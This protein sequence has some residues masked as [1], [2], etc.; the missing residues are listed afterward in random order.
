MTK[1]IN[2][3]YETKKWSIYDDGYNI[4]RFLSN[5]YL[6]KYPI[7]IPF[8]TKVI[9]FG[10]INLFLK[11]KYLM[12]FFRSLGIKIICSWFHLDMSERNYSNFEKFFNYVDKWHV[13]NNEM[14]ENLI[15][16]NI[17]KNKIFIINLGYDEKLFFKKDNEKINLLKKKFNIP[18]YFLI[19]S[20]VKDS[21][22]FGAS[23]EPKAIKR[24]E[25]LVK[26]VRE[27]N[28]RK[29]VY[30]LLTGPSRGFVIQNLKKYGIQFKY[31]GNVKKKDLS[32]LMNLIDVNIISSL[33]EGGPKSAIE[34][35][36]CGKFILSTDVG[37]VKKI[38]NKYKNGIIFNENDFKL[39]FFF[40]SFY[41]FN[42][43][44]NNNNF[45]KEFN[46]KNICIEYKKFL[47]D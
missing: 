28:K 35:T 11:Y 40:D 13:T 22:G 31:F 12:F 20:F 15:N 46:W 8:F 27:I 34:S 4:G 17:S 23:N 37:L 14:R 33:R 2:F 7:P 5:F 18:N 41:K 38:I 25:L 29:K 21:P 10:S 26:V 42:G 47:Y 36:A 16:F 19:G 1:Y 44:K 9:H 3:I 39:D 45:V 32:N 43:I 30:V 6:S 24:P